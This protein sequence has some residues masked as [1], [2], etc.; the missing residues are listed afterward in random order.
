MVGLQDTA[1]DDIVS[2]DTALTLPCQ[3]QSSG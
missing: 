1:S 2:D 3:T